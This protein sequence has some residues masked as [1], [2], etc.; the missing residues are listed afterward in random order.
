MIDCEFDT[1]ILSLV[2]IWIFYV[3]NFILQLSNL[4]ILTYYYFITVYI[5][6][7]IMS[8]NLYKKFRNIAKFLYLY[9][10]FIHEMYKK[11]KHMRKASCARIRL[12]WSL[13]PHSPA[14]GFAH[15]SETPHY[16]PSRFNRQDLHLSRTMLTVS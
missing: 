10:N 13:P 14:G 2:L 6:S 16:Y 8:I 4:I 7:I 15:K 12:T 1:L 9:F 11:K 3:F 5:V